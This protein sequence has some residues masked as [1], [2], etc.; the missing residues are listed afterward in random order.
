MPLS[1]HLEIE[2]MPGIAND[3]SEDFPNESENSSQYPIP[4]FD[5]KLAENYDEAIELMLT[6]ALKRSK[7]KN[8][9]DINFQIDEDMVKIFRIGYKRQVPGRWSVYFT[10]A[11]EELKREFK[12]ANDPEYKEFLRL[13]KKFS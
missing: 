6:K 9:G 2:I 13:Q 7:D 11:V 5:L 8:G 4:T 12:R 10:E 1:S 3:G